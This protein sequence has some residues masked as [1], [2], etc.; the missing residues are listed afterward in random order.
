M[1][2]LL[3]F[4]KPK[5]WLSKLFGRSPLKWIR[6]RKRGWS[7]EEKSLLVGLLPISREDQELIQ[8]GYSLS[9]D[10]EGWT[11]INHKR[12]TKPKQSLLALLREFSSELDKWRSARTN[13]GAKGDLKPE[14]DGWTPARKHAGYEEFGETVTFPPRFDQ[15][16]VEYQHRIDARIEA[17][18]PEQ[19]A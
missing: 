16:P 6:G 4:Q 7:D 14:S 3:N 11:L 9:R 12:I 19:I 5:I 2:V 13:A 15:L 18:T 8:W 17:L 1:S 10:S